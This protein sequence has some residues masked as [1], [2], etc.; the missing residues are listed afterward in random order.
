LPISKYICE[1][2]PKLLG[3]GVAYV[4]GN[5]VF[6]ELTNHIMIL[7]ALASSQTTY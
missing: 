2:I 7:K 3:N 6:P 4:V 1:I 5:D